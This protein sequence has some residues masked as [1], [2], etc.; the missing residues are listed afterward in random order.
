MRQVLPRHPARTTYY[1]YAGRISE[2]YG[3][4]T[5][6]RGRNSASFSTARGTNTITNQTKT[7]LNRKVDMIVIEG[8]VNDAMDS[9][10]VGAVSDMTSE[11]FDTDKLD[12]KTMAGGLEEVLYTLK[13]NHPEAVIV[14]MILY[15]V[16]FSMGRCNDMDEYVDTIKALCDKWGVEYLDLYNDVWFNI[17]FNTKSRVYTN[18]GL[19]P[20]AAGYD[21]L[22]PVLAEF[23]ADAYVKSKGM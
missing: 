5:Y 19:H 18:D 13:E 14:Y 22:T 23:M 2:L 4:K 15:K 8:G 10:P 11:N 3:T 20:N 6:N 9:A 17:K 12:K 21:F 16:D 7:D 1:S